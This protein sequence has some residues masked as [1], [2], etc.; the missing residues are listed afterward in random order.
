MCVCVC[1]CL[2]SSTE[3]TCDKPEIENGYVIGEIQTYKEHEIL[4]FACNPKY[5]PSEERISKCIKLGNTANWSPTP[6]C[7]RK[8]NSINSIYWF[9]HTD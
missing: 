6:V 2:Q 7:E 8:Y 4:D 5:K 3:I 1:L 9:Y